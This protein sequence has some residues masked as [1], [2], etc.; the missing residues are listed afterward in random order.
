[1]SEGHLI[2]RALNLL[3]FSIIMGFVA[4]CFFGALL[5]LQLR[6]SPSAVQAQVLEVGSKVDELS[7]F[8]IDAQPKLDKHETELRDTWRKQHAAE[9]WEKFYE[10]NPTLVKPEDF[11][12]K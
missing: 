1:M 7:A 5:A 2:L 6:V 3:T 4:L 8:V 9:T 11:I 10:A 12:V